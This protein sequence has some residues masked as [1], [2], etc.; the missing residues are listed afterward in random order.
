MLVFGLGPPLA[1][2]WLTSVVPPPKVEQ[3][4]VVNPTTQHVSVDLTG[5]DRKGWLDLGGVGPESSTVIQQVTDHGDLWVFRVSYGGIGIEEL[6]VPRSRLDG[7]GWTITVP[8]EL[9]QVTTT[10]SERSRPDEG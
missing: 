5:A 6:R 8:S 3:L 2:A 9:S 4:I 7:E 10:A 1:M